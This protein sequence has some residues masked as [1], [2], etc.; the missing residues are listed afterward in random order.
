[1]GREL[2]EK[3]RGRMTLTDDQL[4][5]IAYRTF[6]IKSVQPTLW[7]HLNDDVKGRWVLVGREV[8]LSMEEACFS[9][10]P[11]ALKEIL[12]DYP[13]GERTSS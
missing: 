4:G 12:R 7:A 1:M 8:R 3:G 6:Y 2:L 13:G 10:T 9:P 11:E 5:Y